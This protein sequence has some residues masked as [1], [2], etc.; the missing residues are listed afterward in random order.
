MK[1]NEQIIDEEIER[2][3][4]FPDDQWIDA[5]LE[6]LPLDR[7]KLVL[8]AMRAISR[9]ENYSD[10]TVGFISEIGN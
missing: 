10:D 3:L 9:H 2:L 5:K 7:K 6:A 4:V 1:S 8:A